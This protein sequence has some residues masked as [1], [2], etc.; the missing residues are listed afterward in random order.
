MRKRLEIFNSFVCNVDLDDDIYFMI[1]DG[2]N[3]FKVNVNNNICIVNRKGIRVP[4]WRIVRK[5]FNK[6]LTCR[7]RDGDNTNLK[8]NNL[9]LI[10]KT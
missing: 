9:E 6:D 3:R 8:R 10:R 4:I 2:Y 1:T 7:Y 5:C